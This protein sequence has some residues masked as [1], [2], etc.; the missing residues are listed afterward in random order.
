MVIIRKAKKEDVRKMAF[1]RKNTTNKILVKEYPREVIDYL[2]G[3]NKPK[4]F[5]PRLKERDIFCAWE[6]DK[7]MGTIDL[8]GNKIGGVYVKDTLI[9][10]GLGTKLMD[11][12]ENYAKKKGCK[13]VRLY[14]TRFA[15]NFYK[16]RG[17]KK[18]KEFY[19]KTPTFKI[20]NY[21]MEK[22]LE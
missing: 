15:M 16:K 10:Q 12:I 19:W 7:L 8:E 13:K 21:E 5:I 11:F 9:G 22:I 17:Y 18:T 4:D 1:L 20:K 6:G 14:P 3:V 2:N